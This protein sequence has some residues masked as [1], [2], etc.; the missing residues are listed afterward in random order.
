M[1]RR[2]LDH[3]VWQHLLHEP[4]QTQLDRCPERV[5]QCAA[6]PHRR[7]Q[8]GHWAIRWQALV[9]IPSRMQSR[10][11]QLLRRVHLHA[12][13]IVLSLLFLA[14]LAIPAFLG[15]WFA[16]RLAH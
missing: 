11:R 8:A 10:L 5:R 6:C 14:F 4:C 12:F 3:L 7:Q 2:L 15:V 9:M 13:E 16:L 1:S